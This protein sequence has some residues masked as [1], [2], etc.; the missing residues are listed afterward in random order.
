MDLAL[1]TVLLAVANP[2]PDDKVSPGLIGFLVTFGLVLATVLLMRSMV[3]HLR[4]V[5]YAP[6]PGDDRPA[7]DAAPPSTDLSA[8]KGSAGG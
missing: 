4:K 2:P 6:R 7:G 3:G 1:T 5:N 8:G